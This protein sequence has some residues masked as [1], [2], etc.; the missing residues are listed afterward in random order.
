MDSILADDGFNCRGELPP[1]SVVD[2]ARDIERQGLL[3]PIVVCPLAPQ[4]KGLTGKEWRLIAGF[5]RHMA[6]IVL[7]RDKIVATVHLDALSELDARIMNLSENLKRCQLTIVQ[8]A[9][10][11]K[12]MYDL[13]LTEEHMAEKLGQ[14]RSWVQTRKQLLSLPDDIQKEVALGL[15]N[16]TEIK[17]LY[18]IHKTGNE[19]SL[20]EVVRR[21]KDSKQRGVA[22]PRNL[23]PMA[24]RKKQMRS[25]GKQEIEEML[26]YLANCRLGGF[27]T[28]CLS[29][30]AGNLS[31]EDFFKALAAEAARTGVEWHEPTDEEYAQLT[32]TV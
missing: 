19:Q 23:L 7:K 28:K 6:H 1:S 4:I 11:M 22:K 10:A 2:L 16:Q 14:P 8:E 5:R 12:A 21:V 30:A 31:L 3:Q 32:G 15:I 17:Q 9:R 13:G 29:W 20:Y 24:M 18:T 26:V 25:K 27:G